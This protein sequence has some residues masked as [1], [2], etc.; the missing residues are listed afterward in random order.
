MPINLQD[1]PDELLVR[2]NN[3]IPPRTQRIMVMTQKNL[4]PDYERKKIKH[5]ILICRKRI[6]LFFKLRIKITLLFNTL[7]VKLR[8]YSNYMTSGGL[9]TLHNVNC[10]MY[11]PH[12][13]HGSCR[14]CT[15][16]PGEHK[17]RKMIDIFFNLTSTP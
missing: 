11:A 2:I 16:G 4:L 6:L 10:L 15:R 1:L 14:F 13:P 7:S 3:F 12:V 17:Y 8:T 9:I 5:H